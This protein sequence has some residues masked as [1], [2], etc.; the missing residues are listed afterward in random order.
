M[1]EPSRSNITR[2]VLAL[3]AGCTSSSN[4]NTIYFDLNTSSEKIQESFYFKKIILGIF[5]I[6]IQVNFFLK[7]LYLM[8]PISN[9]IK[10][11]EVKQIKVSHIFLLLLLMYF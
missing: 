10:R 6:F 2:C 9:L 11:L 3:E 8:V 1:K 5:I 7:G 4:S